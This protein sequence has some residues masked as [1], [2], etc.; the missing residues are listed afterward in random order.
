MK[1]KLLV[2][3]ALASAG[4]LV[5]LSTAYYAHYRPQR[6][7][8]SNAAAAQRDAEI[9]KIADRVRDLQRQV[10]NVTATNQRLLKQCQVGEIAYNT[11]TSVQKAK[12][13]PPVCK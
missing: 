12:L 3:A 10:D 2:A 9:N 11:M 8:A 1:H 13:M 5:L 7:A 4:V 6:I